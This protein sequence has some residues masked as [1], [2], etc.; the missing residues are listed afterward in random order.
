MKIDTKIGV[1]WRPSFL[2]EDLKLPKKLDLRRTA[3]T[4][5][6]VMLI[7]MSFFHSMLEVL[8]YRI[9]GRSVNPG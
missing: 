1:L 9:L 8:H 7:A 4:K 3:L 6:L 2:F 5:S